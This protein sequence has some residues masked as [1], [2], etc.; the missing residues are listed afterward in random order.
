MHQQYYLPETKITVRYNMV[1]N[2]Q[3]DHDLTYPG[4]KMMI[5]FCYLFLNFTTI[6]FSNKW[7]NPYLYTFHVKRPESLLWIVHRMLK[8]IESLKLIW[9]GIETSNHSSSSFGNFKGSKGSHPE[10]KRLC[11]IP[12]TY[13]LL[14]LIIVKAFYPLMA[15]TFKLVKSASW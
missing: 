5:V 12:G 13:Q 4:F 11:T 9:A 3:T 1:Q 14:S 10:I 6:E 7:R 2:T 8:E 15:S